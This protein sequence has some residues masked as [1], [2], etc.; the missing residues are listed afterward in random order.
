MNENSIILATQNQKKAE[1]IRA[2]FEGSEFV[3]KTLSEAG[4][5]GQANETGETLEDNALQK[6]W[7]AH[8]RSPN[9]SVM[10]DDTGLFIETLNGE[11]G[12][13]SARWAGDDKK[14]HEITTYCLMRM[15][16]KKIRRAVFRTVVCYM[17]PDAVPRY[18]IGE[19]SGQILET[20]RVPPQPQMPYAG[21]F[22][23]DGF[24][25]VLGEMTIEEENAMSHRGIAFRALRE[26]LEMAFKN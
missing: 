18:F 4:I 15:K 12:V 23:P 17:A 1:Q 5:E 21:L 26:H 9:V 19:I 20:P 13:R 7:Y 2:S 11:P 6:V 22:L 24:D 16:G 3:I 8:R 10:A 25:K 14:T